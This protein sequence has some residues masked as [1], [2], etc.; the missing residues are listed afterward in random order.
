MELSTLIMFVP[1]VEDIFKLLVKRFIQ[2]LES[3]K[4]CCAKG[5]MCSMAESAYGEK[6]CNDILNIMTN[7]ER[8]AG[9]G[10]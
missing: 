1:I 6:I 2:I 10:E 9:I 5:Y 3:D 7:I 4:D 8:E